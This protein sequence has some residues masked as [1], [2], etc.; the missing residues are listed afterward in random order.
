MKRDIGSAIDLLKIL[1]LY[2]CSNFSFRILADASCALG[3]SNI[4]DTA[5]RKHFSK[6][7]SFLHETLH[8]MLSSFLP[9]ADIS[10]YEKIKNVLLVNAKMERN[11]NSSAFIHA[12]L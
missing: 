8:S 9:Q 1:F 11:R 4:F 6:S 5:W 12:I 2:A 10:A 3:I 7:A